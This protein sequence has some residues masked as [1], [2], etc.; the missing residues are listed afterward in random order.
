MTIKDNR[1]KKL[2][3]R[4]GVR[5]IPKEIQK[6]A[7]RKLR[8]LNSAHYLNDLRVPPTNKLSRLLGKRAGQYNIRINEDWRLCF[9]WQHCH[10]HNVEVVNYF[11]ET[12]GKKA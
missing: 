5:G 4:E 12:R 2:Y 3:A 1:T 10:S 9:D 7:L 6:I 8:L 11:K